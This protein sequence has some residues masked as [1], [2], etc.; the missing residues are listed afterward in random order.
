MRLKHVYLCLHLEEYPSDLA[1]PFGFRTRY[2]CNFLERRLAELNF[3]AK[4]FSKICV[5]GRH[6][7]QEASPIVS[8]NAVVPTVSFDQDRYESL[9]PDERHEFF[10]GMLVEGLEKC[11]RSHD[12]PLGD[13]EGA[14]GEFRRGG[15]RNEWTH[16]KKL[17]RPVGLLASLQCRLDSERFVL[18]LKLERRGATVF[19]QAI[20]E[21]KPD[22]LIFAYQFKD[23]VLRNGKVIV[24][25]RCGDP[26]FAVE[27][28]DRE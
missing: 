20:L 2:L 24:K 9:G 22:E 14:V 6:H 15:Y 16:Q 10:I 23:V 11:S 3:D 19:Q 1:T 25:D 18:T 12:I 5:Q 7:P 13:L 8:V 21:T 17:L 4:G 27:V 28:P 26:T